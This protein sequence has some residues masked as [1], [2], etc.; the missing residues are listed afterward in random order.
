[1]H[2]PDYRDP[3]SGVSVAPWVR[4][5]ATKDYLD[6]LFL[7]IERENIRVTFN[8]VP[9]LIEQIEHY[10]RGGKDNHLELTSLNPASVN[11]NKKLEILANCFKCHIETMIRPYQRYFALYQKWEETKPTK[12]NLDFSIEEIRDA[13]LWSNLTW[14]DPIFRDEPP[15]KSLFEKSQYFSEEDKNQLFDWQRNHIAKIIP[16]Y[17]KALNEKRI[18]ISFSPYFHPILPLLCDSNSAKEALPDSKLPSE[19]FVHPEDATKQI[20][21]S[22]ELYQKYFGQPMKGMWPSEG[23]ISEEVVRICADY[24]VSWLASDEQVL[25]RSLQKSEMDPSANSLHSI[26]EHPSGIKLF[27]RDQN[28]SDKIGFVYSSWDPEKAAFDFI[29]QV[30]NIRNQNKGNLD[31]AVVPVILDGEN[32]W[33]YYQNDGLEFL[34]ALYKKIS[35]DPEIETVTLCEAAE[36]L[37]ARPLKKIFAGSWIN[38]NFRIWIG[39]EEDNTAWTYLKKARDFLVDFEKKYPGF[40]KNSRAAA[41]REIYNAE[42]SDWFWWY[43]DE[44]RGSD[45]YIFDNLFRSHL[46]KVYELLDEAAPRELRLPIISQSYKLPV[47]LPDALVTPVIDGRLSHFYEWFGAGMF[48]CLG[49]DA[50]MH[51]VSWLISAIF[52]GFDHDK[53]YVRLDFNNQMILKSIKELQLNFKFSLPDIKEIRLSINQLP[54]Q[55]EEKNQYLVSMDDNLELAVDRKFLW[56]DAFGK[57]AFSVEVFENG[58]LIEAWPEKV[59]INVELPEKNKEIFWLQ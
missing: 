44:H 9:S 55:Q 40:D 46:V 57:I 26:Y 6:M 25:F 7:A 14:I 18:D 50:A 45:N 54:H 17:Q 3:H 48:K 10:Q 1:M 42:G 37:I 30:K 11:D 49:S 20:Q 19:T 8:L 12:G 32:A 31:H 5:R 52:F 56:T 59:N 47:Q 28:L 43:G 38:H 41:W 36:N 4:L 15:I 51:R 2:Q 29:F 22:L 21:M 35:E 58:Q 34:R 13:Q 24:G 23:S 53:F 16:A 33:E 39:H 27:F